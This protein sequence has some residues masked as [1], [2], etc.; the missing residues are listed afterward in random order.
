MPWL[1][2]EVQIGVTRSGRR[3]SSEKGVCET[4]RRET[5]YRTA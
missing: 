2:G 4:G 5:L 3:D 1:V